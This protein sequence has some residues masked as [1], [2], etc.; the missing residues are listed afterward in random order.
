MLMDATCFWGLPC[1]QT[2]PFM[3]AWNHMVHGF[4]I[5]C[6]REV[7]GPKPLSL[8]CFM[9]SVGTLGGEVLCPLNS[10]YGDTNHR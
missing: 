7:R 1:P 3:V 10:V 9:P 5:F 8:K 4:P 2:L 6:Q